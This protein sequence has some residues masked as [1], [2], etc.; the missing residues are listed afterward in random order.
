MAARRLGLVDVCLNTNF[1]VQI[2][3]DRKAGGLPPSS[4]GGAAAQRKSDT[5]LLFSAPLRGQKGVLRDP[6]RDFADQLI[7]VVTAFKV[8]HKT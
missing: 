4:K 5:S 2:A 1:Q 7:L 6:S 3:A 8:W